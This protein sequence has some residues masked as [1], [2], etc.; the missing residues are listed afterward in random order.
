[1][2]VTHSQMLA[3]RRRKQA[4]K[5]RLARIAKQAKKSRNRNPGKTAAYEAENAS[6]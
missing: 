3:A 2:T 5:K 1:M 4:A 6:P